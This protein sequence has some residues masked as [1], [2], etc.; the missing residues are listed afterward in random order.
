LRES[1]SV[2]FLA[3]NL[4]N[5]IRNHAN[6][7]ELAL[8]AHSFGGFVVR[9]MLVMQREI[10][11]LL[12]HRVKQITFVASPHHSVGLATALKKIPFFGSDQVE[13]LSGNSNVLVDLESAWE[14]WCSRMVPKKCQVRCI[15]GTG[16][17]V[18]PTA[19]ARGNDPQAVPILGAGHSEIINVK[20]ATDEVVLTI[21]RFFKEAGFEPEAA[22]P[23]QQVGIQKVG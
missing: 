8:V 22:Q 12:D 18:V 1:P 4:D 10:N 6:A 17:N 20:N 16:D 21:T 14:A 5:W 3:R 13:E 7:V 2:L 11:S 19:S 15:Y 9:K 23:D